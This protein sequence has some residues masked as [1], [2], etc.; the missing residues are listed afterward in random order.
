MVAAN[1][2]RA[3]V[4]AVSPAQNP[5]SP[6]LHRRE[7]R[8]T[9]SLPEGVPA[10]RLFGSYDDGTWVALVL[11]DVDG[12]HPTAPW[13]TEELHAVLRALGSLAEYGTPAPLPTHTS[14][15][16]VLAKDFGGWSRLAAEPSVDLDVWAA[17]K[18]PELCAL[19]ERGLRSVAGETLCHLDVRA[20]N[21]LIRGDGSVVLVDWPWACALRGPRP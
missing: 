11:E 15:T 2:A 20:D 1:G 7:A 16:E 8:N 21:L 17:G 18:L 10:P 14:V 19:A 4:K 6:T 3:F 9:E 12:R 5:R 13:V